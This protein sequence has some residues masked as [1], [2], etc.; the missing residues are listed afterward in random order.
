MFRPV[1]AIIRFYPKLYAKKRVF[2]VFVQCAPSRIDVEISS[3]TC[4][5]KFIPYGLDVDSVSRWSGPVD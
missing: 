2:V 3:S 4:Q 5:A 1:V